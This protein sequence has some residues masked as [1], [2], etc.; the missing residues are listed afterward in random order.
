[1]YLSARRIRENTPSPPPSNLTSDGPANLSCNIEVDNVPT[2]SV[3]STVAVVG[4]IISIQ[5][6][7]IVVMMKRENS[8]CT[9]M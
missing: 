2:Y 4:I 3:D 5:L 9:R 8:G 1:M 6:I 7:R